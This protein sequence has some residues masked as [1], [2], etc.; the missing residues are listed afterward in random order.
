[1]KQFLLREELLIISAVFHGMFQL[2]ELDKPWSRENLYQSP[3]EKGSTF[4]SCWSDFSAQQTYGEGV[5]S[6]LRSSLWFCLGNAVDCNNF[7]V[8][9]LAPSGKAMPNV[10]PWS[11]RSAYFW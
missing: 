4:V 2:G 1:M 3:T 10:V 7:I 8:F 5:S 9:F 6:A 11:E